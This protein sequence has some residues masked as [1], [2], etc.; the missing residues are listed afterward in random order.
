MHVCLNLNVS[1]L[2]IKV[3]ERYS[4]FISDFWQASSNLRL[5]K[6]FTNGESDPNKSGGIETRAGWRKSS[7]CTTRLHC[8]HQ[9][10]ANFLSNKMLGLINP[11]NNFI[12][13]QLNIPRYLMSLSDTK[14]TLSPN[15]LMYYIPDWGR[16][17][18]WY[19]SAPAS[20]VSYLPIYLHLMLSTKCRLKLC[21]FERKMVAADFIFSWLYILL[22]CCC[23]FYILLALPTFQYIG[24][25]H[26]SSAKAPFEKFDT[27]KNETG[28]QHSF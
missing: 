19:W 26:V 12:L 6:H 24:H 13:V 1:Y 9:G 2:Q 18:H 28:R 7:F 22:L 27:K 15:A 25:T 23:W 4:V 5:C 21:S 11:W 17:M 16:L 20:C 8:L 10:P 3:C 14:R